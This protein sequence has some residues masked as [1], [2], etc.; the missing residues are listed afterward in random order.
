QGAGP[1]TGHRCPGLDFATYF[2]AVFTMVLL[3]GYTWELP[4]QHFD[5]DWSKVPPEVRDGLRARVTVIPCAARC[6][7][8]SAPSCTPRS[9]AAESSRPPIRSLRSRTAHR[10]TPPRPAPLS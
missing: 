7:R 4:P 1:I 9:R 3:R 2:M 5:Y 10:G 8:S 6:A